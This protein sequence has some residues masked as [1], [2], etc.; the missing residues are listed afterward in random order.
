MVCPDEPLVAALLQGTLNDVEVA[1]VRRHLGECAPCRTR[2]RSPGGLAETLHDFDSR[3]SERTR[4]CFAPGCLIDG[5]YRVERI[6][7]AGGM[8]VV[9]HAKDTRLGRDVAIKLLRAGARDE[10]VRRFVREAEITA[11]IR[12]PH[13]VRVFD[14]SRL[15]TGE[16]YIV[17]ERLVGRDARHLL[18][19]DGPRPV[20]EALDLLAQA[21]R[22]VGAAHRQGIVHR[23]LKPAN[24]FLCEPR[25]TVVVLDF[26]VSKDPRPALASPIT[27][28]NLLGTPMYMPP[29]QLR[30]PRDVDPRAD[31]WALGTILYELLTGNP[32]FRRATFE[33]TA[34]AIHQDAVPSF[35]PHVDML[36]SCCLAK[37]PRARFADANALLAFLER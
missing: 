32:P 34:R 14:V 6:L 13:V 37:D 24:L 20:A 19:H 8:A 22:G 1:R 2:V 28:T 21:C 16:P 4:L 35:D 9:L 5:R 3:P 25:S 11:G 30:A 17:F 36:L 10:A 23:D 7:G 26:G 18:D 12:S 29:E 27:H 31:V 15:D 33:D